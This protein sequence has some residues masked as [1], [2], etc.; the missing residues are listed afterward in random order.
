[1]AEQY[2]VIHP[3]K[4]Y[5]D[6]LNHNIRPDG[7]EFD[8]WRPV[9]INIGSITTA[10]GSAIVK[11]GNTNVV[12]GIRAELAKPKAI[13]PANGF[14]VPHIE[15]T[16]LCSPKYRSG[17]S[18]E[19]AEN[20]SCA[21]YDILMN[22]N[23]IDLKQLCIA[24]EKLVWCLYCDIACLDHDGCIVDAAVI[25]IIGALRNL[26]LPKVTYNAEIDSIAVDTKVL[27]PIKI[28]SSPISTTLMAFDDNVLITDPTA[29]EENLSSAMLTIAVCNG[30]V[31][32]ILKPGG[33]PFSQE[34]MDHCIRQALS[35]ERSI[36][37][38]L[39]NLCEEN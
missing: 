16:S 9:A 33:T 12:C 13:E 29:E 8:K 2:K 15:L 10:D 18:N 25:A 31:C 17:T 24:K 27:T 37:K 36:L 38:L 32:F 23:C 6:Y 19:D 14:I 21:V 22:S 3:V 39:N 34:Q 28:T 7:R 11:I 26:K 35:R 30:E 5:R 20:H 4:Y 1:M